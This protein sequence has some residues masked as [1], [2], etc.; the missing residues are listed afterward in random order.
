MSFYSVHKVYKTR[1]SKS[2]ILIKFKMN[3]T[4]VNLDILNALTAFK[5]PRFNS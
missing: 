1:V 4:I 3:V 2:D 5:K